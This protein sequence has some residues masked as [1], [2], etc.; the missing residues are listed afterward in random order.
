MPVTDLSAVA[1][2]NLEAHRGTRTSFGA[3]G[4][5]AS[6]AP[7]LWGNPIEYG[8]PDRTPAPTRNL[9]R[10]VIMGPRS[11]RGIIVKQALIGFE[12]FDMNVVV[13]L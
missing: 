2:A 10:V 9:L 6:R 4:R 3:V 8:V 13:G 1:A 12:F 5:A 11:L 7:S